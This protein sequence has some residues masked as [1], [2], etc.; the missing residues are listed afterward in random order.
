MARQYD[1]EFIPVNRN[2]VLSL[3]RAVDDDVERLTVRQVAAVREIYF[4]DCNK[5]IEERCRA[6]EHFTYS[7]SEARLPR[8]KA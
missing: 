5:T 4:L 1:P 3:L 8:V 2:Q 6:G 7:S